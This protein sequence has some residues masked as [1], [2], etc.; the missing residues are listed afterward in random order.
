MIYL[1]ILIALN[2][3]VQSVYRFLLVLDTMI[4][5]VGDISVSFLDMIITFM[6]ISFF[7]FAFWKGAKH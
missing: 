6:I 4:F 1:D 3:I 7:A 5:S 2:F